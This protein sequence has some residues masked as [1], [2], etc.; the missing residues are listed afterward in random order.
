MRG[1]RLMR[2][3]YW[4]SFFSPSRAMRVGCWFGAFGESLILRFA[5]EVWRCQDFE[6]RMA[7]RRELLFYNFQTNTVQFDL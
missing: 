5:C 1:E 7:L 2:A 3:G 6:R 4:M